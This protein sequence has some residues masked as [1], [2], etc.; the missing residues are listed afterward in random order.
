MTTPFTP[1]V[2]P[3][4]GRKVL[5]GMLAF[6]GVIFAV[7]GAFVFFAL[8]SWPGLSSNRAYEDGIKYNITLDAARSQQTLGWKSSIVLKQD[9]GFVVRFYDKDGSSLT[10]LDVMVQFVRPAYEGDDR[11]FSLVELKSG[12]YSS[13]VKD[14]ERGQWK[15]ELRARKDEKTRFFIIHDLLVK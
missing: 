9:G 5:Y 11:K 8:D 15:V 3:I 1:V 4:T 6:F 7:N 2:R 10:G 12:V 13:T 14:L